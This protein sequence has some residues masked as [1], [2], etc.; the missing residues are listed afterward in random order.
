MGVRTCTRACVNSFLCVHHVN[1]HA[2]YL[3]VK[4]DALYY[5]FMLYNIVYILN[6]CYRL[7]E[8]L[9]ED[10]LCQLSYS[11]KKP[12][13]LSLW[14]PTYSN[15]FTMTKLTKLIFPVTFTTK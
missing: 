4:F 2:S 11:L 8:G 7:Q 12:H 9:Y 10:W 14:L 13:L 5:I 15:L 3:F 1:V 6:Y